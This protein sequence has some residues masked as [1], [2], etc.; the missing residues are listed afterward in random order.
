MDFVK[1]NRKLGI[2]ITTLSLKIELLKLRPDKLNISQHGQFEYIYR[3]LNRNNLS[4]R[5]TNHVGQLLPLNVKEIKKIYI[6]FKNFNKWRR[7]F[8]K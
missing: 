8:R 7:I 6:R 1:I 3:F 4:I 5:A 2:P